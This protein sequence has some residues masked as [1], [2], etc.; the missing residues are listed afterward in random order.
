MNRLL[1][2]LAIA[3]LFAGCA[4]YP[5]AGGNATSAGAGG[6]GAKPTIK[7]LDERR[8]ALDYK[9]DQTAITC[10]YG[11]CQESRGTIFESNLFMKRKAIGYA[12]NYTSYQVTDFKKLVTYSWFPNQTIMGSEIECHGFSV[13]DNPP[14]KTL[15]NLGAEIIERGTCSVDG[16]D[17]ACTKIRHNV[18]SSPAKE[19]VSYVVE[20]WIWDE[21]G[22]TL[23][24]YNH[25]PENAFGAADWNVT[26]TMSN[27]FFPIF[28]NEDFSVPSPC[29][30]VD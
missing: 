16:K 2:L 22:L 27:F 24:S 21:K 18:Y 30:V 9:Y 8:L 14:N 11:K 29:S 5:G 1:V 15:E 26:I 4:E 12:E 10:Q 28:K 23:T 3:V 13:A 17:V 7:Q 19:T 6:S 25:K 20:Q